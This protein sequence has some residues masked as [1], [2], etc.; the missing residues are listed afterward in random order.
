MP[1]LRLLLILLSALG[2]AIAAAQPAVEP[3]APLRAAP[4]SR[5]SF[6]ATFGVPSAVA[7]RAGTAFIG[8]TFVTPR[9]GIDGLGGDGDLVAGY[10]VGDPVDGLGLTFGIAVTGLDPPGDAG[11]LSVT[12]SRLLRAGGTSATFAGLSASNLAAWGEAADRPEMYALYVSHLVG[13]STA[14]TELPVQ[15]SMGYG[16]D[17]T[18]R[19]DGSGRLD[20]GLFA[21]VGLGLT[22]LVSGSLSATATQVNLG[23]TLSLPGTGASVSL[24]LLDAADTTDHRQVSLSVGL[25]F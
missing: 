23:A 3:P 9:A 5:L 17:T 14:R 8:A 7:P 15:I 4:D 2:P 20:D 6:P 12:A 19:S 18:R 25:G 22:P 16:T 13:L 10:A 21:G 1:S 24:G 11:A